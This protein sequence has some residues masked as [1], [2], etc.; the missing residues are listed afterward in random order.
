MSLSVTVYVIVC[1]CLCHC[2]LLSMSLCVT[3]YNVQHDEDV[4]KLNH[5]LKQLQDV[6]QQAQVCACLYTYVCVYVCL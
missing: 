6:Q 3:I 2:V 5:A 1:Y 4:A